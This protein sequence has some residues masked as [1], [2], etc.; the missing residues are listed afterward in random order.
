MAFVYLFAVSEPTF[1][2]VRTYLPIETIT[3]LSFQISTDT[4]LPHLFSWSEAWFNFKS[5]CT[6][7]HGRFKLF[8]IPSFPAYSSFQK[9]YSISHHLA[10]Q[11][12]LYSDASYEI[13]LP[14]PGWHPSSHNTFTFIWSFQ[15]IQNHFSSSQARVTSPKSLTFVAFPTH[16]VFNLNLIHSIFTSWNNDVQSLAS[17]VRLTLVQ[18]IPNIA[19]ISFDLQEHKIHNNASPCY[20]TFM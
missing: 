13:D 4:F 9:L 3:L 11:G 15:T 18:Q 2:L 5:Y 7:L 1:H 19:W 12:S 8:S 16:T 14:I 20:G 6:P 17:W 10:D